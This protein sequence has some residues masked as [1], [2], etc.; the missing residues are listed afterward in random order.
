[1]TASAIRHCGRQCMT[2]IAGI[3]SGCPIPRSRFRRR[4]SNCGSADSSM[5]AQMRH[6]TFT[7]QVPGLPL[8]TAASPAR[9]PHW[10]EGAA[11]PGR[12]KRRM[13]VTGVNDGPA[14]ARRRLSRW[15]DGRPSESLSLPGTSLGSVKSCLHRAQCGS[16]AIPQVTSGLPSHPQMRPER[17]TGEVRLLQ[18]RVP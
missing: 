14:I 1:M 2:C 3:S 4:S 16:S 6:E 11:G 9:S 18:A 17:S 15:P 12:R 10:V 5:S 13:S 8:V 7:E